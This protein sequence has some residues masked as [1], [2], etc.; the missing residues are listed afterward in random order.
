MLISVV[1]AAKLLS[2]RT[3]DLM[4][5][6]G[7]DTVVKTYYDCTTTDSVEVCKH[8]LKPFY[9]HADV[10]ASIEEDMQKMPCPPVDNR[11]VKR[12]LFAKT[13]EQLRAAGYN[14]QEIDIEMNRREDMF[15]AFKLTM[16]EMTFASVCSLLSRGRIEPFFIVFLGAYAFMFQLLG[17]QG[18][19]YYEKDQE[20]KSQERERK[21]S[22]V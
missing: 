10:L 4:E 13:R 8:L 20:Q 21:N 2:E 12:G 19:R 11:V 18:M 16:A 3:T 7:L 5:E 14:G 6:A 9:G 22:I 15:A 1:F 17:F